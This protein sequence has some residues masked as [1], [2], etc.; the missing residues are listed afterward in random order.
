MAYS[1][2]ETT[3]VK[4]L[5]DLEPLKNGRPAKWVV[6]DGE[7]WYWAGKIREALY[8]ARE[9]FP[10]KYP[11][12]AKAG[13]NYTIDVLDLRTI[14]ARPKENTSPVEV[15][16][17]PTGRDDPASVTP[18]HGID[19]AGPPGV[20]RT[21]VEPSSVTDIIA[22]AMRA[23]PTNDK[24]V[25]LKAQVHDEELQQ[26]VRWADSRTPRWMVVY[27]KSTGIL[28]LA[29]WQPGVPHVGLIP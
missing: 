2:S 13:K 24:L 20:P 21:I 9:V 19:L 8:I 12:L 7:A 26:L 4:R 5:T 3:L 11:E 6:K 28:T 17:A 29:P 16:E 1:R 22:Y 23:L 25:F 18:I 15:T 10:H 14:Q 27:S